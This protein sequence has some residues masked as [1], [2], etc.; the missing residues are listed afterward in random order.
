MEHVQSPNF[1]TGA[2]KSGLNVNVDNIQ[3][4]LRSFYN[5]LKSKKH[6][7]NSSLRRLNALESYN[8][9]KANA[10]QVYENKVD[11][12]NVDKA[13]YSEQRINTV[14][15]EEAQIRESLE[16][17]KFAFEQRKSHFD[18]IENNPEEF[19]L[20]GKELNEYGLYVNFINQLISSIENRTNE[21]EDGSVST[22]R[23]QYSNMQEEL[24]QNDT[25]IRNTFARLISAIHNKALLSDD[26]GH[27]GRKLN[28]YL[29]LSTQRQRPILNAKYEVVDNRVNILNDDIQSINSDIESLDVN[30]ETYSID[31]G[32]LQD[33]LQVKTTEKN[34]LLTYN[35]TLSEKGQALDAEIAL[36]NSQYSKYGEWYAL[37]SN[38]YDASI[39]Q[40]NTVINGYIYQLLDSLIPFLQE[41][42]TYS[43]MVLDVIQT[44]KYSG[45]G[46]PFANEIEDLMDAK[47][48]AYTNMS[49]NDKLYN[50]TQGYSTG[51]N[52]QPLI[53]SVSLLGGTKGTVEWL[54][55]QFTITCNKLIEVCGQ[56]AT[57]QNDLAELNSN[58][59]IKQSLLEN[60]TEIFN[61]KLEQIVTSNISLPLDLSS[62]NSIDSEIVTLDSEYLTLYDELEVFPNQI[63]KY[64]ELIT[65][66]T[67]FKTA[68]ESEISD[69]PTARTMRVGHVD[70]AKTNMETM[71]EEYSNT[72]KVYKK[73]SRIKDSEMGYLN[74]MIDL[75]VIKSKYS[76][77][78]HTTRNWFVWH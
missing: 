50:S 33:L 17:I 62:W 5:E 38:G 2:P 11:T 24:S 57:T 39:N 46:L 52:F 30:S 6:L 18:Y 47:R 8:N 27:Q 10:I 65:R 76:D 70:D 51:D 12:I 60:N 64:N 41:S 55:Y 49:M 31:L 35:S 77:L 58:M 22:L 63:T 75:E 54:D 26:F 3:Q 14:I 9:R 78:N 20:S 56:L 69:Y 68:L 34:E 45:L 53:S 40:S 67:D 42:N 21:Y 16:N 72:S 61:S 44:L 37:E 48:M 25:F 15:S 4:D 43:W 28:S 59:T 66:L 13:S 1:P 19:G 36:V 29:Y 71:I 7:Q 23:D 74:P 32:N 73:E